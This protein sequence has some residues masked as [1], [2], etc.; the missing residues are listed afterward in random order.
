MA[1]RGHQGKDYQTC[2]A[3]A[4]EHF[5]D[6]LRCGRPV[7]KQLSGRHRFG[8]TLDLITPW[9]KGGRMTIDNSALSHNCC[10]AGYRDGR[11]L[12]SVV[13]PKARYSASRAW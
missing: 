12:R 13:R 10:N 4:L 5:D 2:R 3:Y 6:C 9:S 1:D 8:P 11:R 7:D